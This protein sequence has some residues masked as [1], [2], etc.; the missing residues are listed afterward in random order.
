[1]VAKRTF[2]PGLGGPVDEDLGELGAVHAEGC[3]QVR[4]AGL[5]VVEL[6][7]EGA[8]RVGG[9]DAEGVEGVAAVAD[10]VPD[11]ELAQHAQRVSLDRDAG[12]QG[13]DV[14]LGLDDVDGDPLLGEQDR[15]RCAGGAGADHE[16][17]TDSGH[18]GTSRSS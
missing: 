7:D 13:G 3:G 6:E 17:G 8:G 14:G 5:V 4:A 16:N 2:A 9:A 18:G 11:A 10:L 12:A 15:G 1:M